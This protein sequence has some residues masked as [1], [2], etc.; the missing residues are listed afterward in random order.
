VLAATPDAT[1]VLFDQPHV[2]KDAA[3][4]ASVRL[5]LQGGDFFKDSLPVC[6]A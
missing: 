6:D 2:V 3:G 4:A 5:K 1:G